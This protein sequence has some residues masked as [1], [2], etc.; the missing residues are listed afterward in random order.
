MQKYDKFWEIPVQRAR[1]GAKDADPGDPLP[2]L[3]VARP[4]SRQNAMEGN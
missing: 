3:F 2:H 1:T 4:R